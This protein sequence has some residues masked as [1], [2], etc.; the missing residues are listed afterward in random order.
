VFGLT[1]F[2]TLYGIVFL[3]HQVGSF[4]GAWMG[5]VV[6]DASAI[7]TSAGARYRDRRHRLHP[8]VLMDERPPRERQSAGAPSRRPPS[9]AFT[10]RLG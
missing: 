8:A 9:H 10:A 1:H 5:G 2:N 3:S 4:F 6:F 7:T